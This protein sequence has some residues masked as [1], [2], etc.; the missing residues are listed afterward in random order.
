MSEVD[1]K[2]P[3][4]PF[5]EQVD[6][7]LEGAIDMHCHPGPSVM[8][9][10]I[11][12]IEAM[13]DAAANGMRGVMIKDHYYSATPI[14]EL[15]NKQ[16]KHVQVE[17]FS[18][19]PLNNTTGGLNVFAVD[20][21]LALGGKLVWMPTFSAKNHICKPHGGFPHTTMKLMDP[22]PL[23]VLNDDG[24]LVDDVFPI[25]DKIAEYDAILSGG[26]L[27]IDEIFPLFVEAKKRGVNRLLCNHPS[28]LIGAS[29]EDISELS[30]MGSYIEHSLCMFIPEAYDAFTPET[31]DELIKAGG[32]DKTI[33]GSDLGQEGNCWPAKGFRNVICICLDLGYSETDI[34]KMICGNPA[35]LLGLDT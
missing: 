4:N 19:V 5:S 32:I 3:I 22:S 23:T 33:L 13:L 14:T 7:I 20:H 17:L 27:S 30:R 16:Y 2:N 18:G 28:F 26:H 8:P 31:L 35:D 12:H 10:N 6:R 11:N 34:K 21:G 29:L 24:S 1:H 9:R 15:L 25:L